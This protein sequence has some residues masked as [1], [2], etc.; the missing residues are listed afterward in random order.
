MRDQ[1]RSY[2]ASNTEASGETGRGE[3][4]G[5]VTDTS[6]GGSPARSESFQH[7]LKSL[8]KSKGVC[9]TLLKRE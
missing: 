9:I 4:A 2:G 1:I 8:R 3:V 7:R 5:S 6:K